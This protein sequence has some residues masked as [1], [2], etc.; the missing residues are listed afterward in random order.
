MITIVYWMAGL[1]D[2]FGVFIQILLTLILCTQLA[3]SY[4]LF[5]SA[6]APNTEAALAMVVPIMMPLLIFAG[7]FLN[8][9]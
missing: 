6:I 7:F 5:I 4:G 3:V 9:V 2:N 8:D 1:N